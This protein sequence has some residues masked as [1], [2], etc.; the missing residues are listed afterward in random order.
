ME[1]LAAAS[2]LPTL[3]NFVY[4]DTPSETALRSLVNDLLL[5]PEEFAVSQYELSSKHDLRPLVLRTAW[6]YLELGG[7]LKRGTP[8]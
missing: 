6:T 2:D 8:F 7:A 3:E 4:G 1:V 5:S